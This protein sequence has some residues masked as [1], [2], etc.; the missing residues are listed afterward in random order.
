MTDL[1]LT[2]CFSC[3]ER[4]EIL[5]PCA[6]CEG[7]FCGNCGPKPE[8]HFCR[9]IDWNLLAEVAGAIQ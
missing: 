1:N 7:F 6:S 8:W 4:S 2:H 3:A 5:R 9:A